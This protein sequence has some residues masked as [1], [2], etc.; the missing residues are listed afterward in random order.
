MCALA[1]PPFFRV[2]LFLFNVLSYLID[3]ST[4]RKS[5]CIL[6]SNFDIKLINVLPFLKYFNSM[7]GLM[8]TSPPIEIYRLHFHYR[9]TVPSLTTTVPS[10]AINLSACIGPEAILMIYHHAHCIRHGQTETAYLR[11][12]C[13]AI[14]WLLSE[15]LFCWPLSYCYHTSSQTIG[16]IAHQMKH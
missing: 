13:G 15:G 8:T 4:L 12:M 7:L 14:L 1:R 5:T 2:H 9:Q 11:C 6:L 10:S 3:R 16:S